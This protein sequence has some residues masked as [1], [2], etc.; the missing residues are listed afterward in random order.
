MNRVNEPLSAEA[1]VIVDMQD[2]HK[3]YGPIE[4]LKGIDFRLRAGRARALVGENGAGKSTLL[5]VIAGKSD[6]WTGRYDLRNTP[7]RFA[8]VRAAQRAGIALIHQETVSLPTLTVAENVLAG[9]LPRRGPFIDR[10]AL[11][12]QAEA[13]LARLGVTLDL[14]RPAS[15]LNT[16]ELQLVD[17]ARAL[18]ADPSVLLLDEPTASLPDEGRERLFA[19]VRKLLDDQKSIVFI[20]HHLNEVFEHCH[21]LTILRDG[22]VVEDV[23]TASSNAA[24]AAEAMIG[25]ELIEV[26]SRDRVSTV[27]DEVAFSTRALSDGSLLRDIDLDVHA[28]EIVGVS[29]LLGAG[30]AELIAAILGERRVT[31]EMTLSGKA[32]K[33]SSVYAAARDGVGV[34]TE[35]RKVDGLLLE[36]PIA[37]NLG[38]ASTLL[39][40]FGVYSARKERA[41]AERLIRALDI[42][43]PIATMPVR[44]LSGGNQQKVTLGKW[45]RQPLDLIILHEPTRGVD[46]GAKALLHEQIR[47]LAASGTA[48]LLVS[49]DLPEVVALAD[50]AV[51]LHRGRLVST[52]LADELNQQNLLLA[53]FASNELDETRTEGDTHD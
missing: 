32:W 19:V 35:D 25:R 49:S 29:G 33:P 53:A 13:A 5:K 27:R 50:R 20:S 2:I 3:S 11:H 4:V 43:P 39:R 30:Q 44:S 48:V 22:K 41:E 51:V 31:G 21:D 36:E 1:E 52:L 34:V 14:D 26:D 16:A 37:T 10:R 12:E 47:E 15:Q 45:L 7:V 40:T 28:G 17:I 46:V 23:T 9:R 6:D 24:D 42:K 18:L 8:S 38:L